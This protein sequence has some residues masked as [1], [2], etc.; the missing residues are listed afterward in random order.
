VRTL[1]FYYGLN[2]RGWLVPPA[3][4]IPHL[5]DE[6]ALVSRLE[7]L[8]LAGEVPAEAE[9]FVCSRMAL[10][11]A[12]VFRR[13]TAALDGMEPTPRRV[14]FGE[15][16]EPRGLP[17]ETLSPRVLDIDDERTIRRLAS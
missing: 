10:V 5:G 3:A 6:H 8:W 11:D 7:T 2:E 14:R 1:N 4:S 17:D 9:A 12:L 15:S 16:P 13:T